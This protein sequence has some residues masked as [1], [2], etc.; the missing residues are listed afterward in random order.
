MPRPDR[1][2]HG[3][4]GAPRRPLRRVAAL[5]LLT[6]AGQAQPAGATA[7]A[8]P[9]RPSGVVTWAASA[10]LAGMGSSGRGYRMVVRTSTGGSGLRIRVSN[11]FGDR[12]LTVDRAYAGLRG[13]GAALR[14][15][16]NRPLTFGGS[17]TVTVP[18]GA[19]VWSDPLPGRWPAAAAL[20]VSLR[21]PGAAGP[22][23]GHALALRTSYL[24]EGDHTAE[25]SGAHWTRTT[26]AWWYLD[27]V[28]VRP[29]RPGTG[30]VAALG[31]SVTDGRLSTADR[32]RRWP[33]D[34]ARRLRTARAAVQGVADEGISGN[35][36][37]RDGGGQ[38]ALHRLDRD[39]LSQPGVR[40]VIL[41]EG[42]NDL[43]GIPGASAAALVAGYREIVR[44]AHA[45]GV[46]VVGA[47]VGP[48]KGWPEWSPAAEAVR[49]DVNR[50]IRTGGA[51]DAVADFDRALRDPGDPERMRPGL[52]GGDHLHPGDRGMRALAGA[53]DLTSLDCGRRVRH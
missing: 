30:A 38:S 20:A 42:V 27:A 8:A 33:D 24:S 50:F 2:A 28:S 48:F 9:G 29:E 18:A 34:L 37:L 19:V 25:E 22:A 51:F 7:P 53:V 35:Q 10:D 31:D 23:T 49:R 46:C 1:T 13:D 43:K 39:V 17:R 15:G 44:R 5:L 41:F 26:R 14:E 21:T 11:A 45:A 32:D 36:L 4:P 12:P 47:T 16:S 40:T 52:D 6:V 3:V